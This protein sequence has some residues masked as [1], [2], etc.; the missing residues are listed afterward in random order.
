MVPLGL[1]PINDGLC[2]FALVDQGFAVV[3]SKP[4]K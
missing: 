1:G 2:S 4:N 3:G